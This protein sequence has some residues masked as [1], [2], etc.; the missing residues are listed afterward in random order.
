MD[1]KC[2]LVV[3]CKQRWVRVEYITSYGFS[4][5]FNTERLIM[6]VDDTIEYW[7]IVI[8]PKT[9]KNTLKSGISSRKD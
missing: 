3:N 9:G 5:I 2:E 4:I 8:V 7:Y 1:T 6:T